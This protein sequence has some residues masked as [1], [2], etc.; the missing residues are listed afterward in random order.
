MKNHIQINSIINPKNKDMP[1]TGMPIQFL[2][3]IDAEP[4]NIVLGLESPDDNIDQQLYDVLAGTDF[5]DSLNGP[6]DI[7]KS[8]FNYL[9]KTRNVMRARPHLVKNQDPRTAVKMFNYAIKYFN[10]PYRDK[11]LEVLEKEEDRLM[12][13]GAI[14]YPDEPFVYGIDGLED[15]EEI[16]GIAGGLGRRGFFRRMREKVSKAVK[17]VAQGVKKVAGKAWNAFKRFN[18]LSLTIRIGVLA[19]INM[20]MFRMASNLYPA[21]E[22]DK[23][24]PDLV[25]RSKKAYD[26]VKNLF[27][28]KL[29][30]RESKL[31][32]A[33]RKGY[34]R[35]WTKKLPENEAE[36]KASVSQIATEINQAE[37]SAEEQAERQAAE[38]GEGT[39]GVRG[40]GVATETIIAAATPVILA[41][42][43]L[44]TDAMRKAGH[45]GA[46]DFV[47]K[48]AKDKM[49]KHGANIP[50]E[51]P[52]PSLPETT[53]KVPDEA[54]TDTT[55]QQASTLI[56]KD[57][58]QNLT[59][60]NPNMNDAEER[61]KKLK[62]WLIIG[63]A[64]VVGLGAVYLIMKKKP[65]PALNGLNGL[66]GLDGTR[67]RRRRKSTS[68]VFK[69]AA[70]KR[71]KR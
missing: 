22:P 26:K 9:V 34:S 27:V 67:R 55:P 38:Q 25:E 23:F 12:G 30:G 47:D 2:N 16:D 36:A 19:A 1:L 5:E 46:A 61:K 45:G 60:N 21:I 66:D 40:L 33:I 62:K 71:K 70:P 39:N 68:R 41:I 53:Q 13:L 65:Q 44:I 42:L 43:K 7:Q 49:R 56:R 24:A 57:I 29:A 37:A 31:Q 20:N 35:K 6:A 59:Q 50:E 64:A 32:K 14:V 18:P 28:N 15:D 11:A 58:R 69:L 3:G 17:K 51:T 54:P 48:L 4:D 8:M 63:G 52:T 10:T